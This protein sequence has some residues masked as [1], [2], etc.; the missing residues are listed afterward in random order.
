[1]DEKPAKLRAKLVI[2]GRVQGVWFRGTTC[3]QA[4]RH[5]VRGWVRN[6]PDGTV[7][8]VL[9]GDR[10]AVMEVVAWCYRGPALAQVKCV[11]VEWQEPT[12]EFSGFDMR[13]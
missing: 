4:R 2:H 7:E 5:G 11:D 8:A 9:E 12:G 3:E 1:M 6:R 10:K 13:W